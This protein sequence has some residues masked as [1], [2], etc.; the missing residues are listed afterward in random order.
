MMLPNH[1][2]ARF[3]LHNL[4]SANPND[5]MRIIG[6]NSKHTYTSVASHV[7]KFLWHQD[8]ARRH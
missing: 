8:I 1:R 6:A 3:T 7:F 4:K 5:G 2:E